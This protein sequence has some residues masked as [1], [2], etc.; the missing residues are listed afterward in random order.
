MAEQNTTKGDKIDESRRKFLKT[1]G[2]SA[3]GAMVGL[4][5]LKEFGSLAFAKRGPDCELTKALYE[6]RFDAKKCAGC[7]LCETACSQFHEGMV[8]PLASRN[9]FVLKPVVKFNGV[10]ALSANAPGC[11]QPL[12]EATFAEFSQNHFCEQCDSPECQD[13]CPVD[14]IT[15]DAKTGARVVDENKC[16]G[17]GQC[18]TACQFGMIRVNPVT[19][20]AVKCDF[21]GGDPQ[22]AAWCPT[23]AITFHKL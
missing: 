9:N 6:L 16:I 15:I 11:P 19:G 5:V 20:T 14:A 8:N 7:N 4:F 10:S 22:C 17:C 23:D 12:A 3:G 13:V 1:A 2:K 18:E 21:C